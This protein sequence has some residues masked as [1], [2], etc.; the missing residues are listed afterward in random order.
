MKNNILVLL[1]LG[2]LLS[3][4]KYSDEYL[5]PHLDKSKAYFASPVM[6]TRTVI[7]GEPL[8]FKIGAAVAYDATHAAEYT[9]D[10]RISTFPIE[11]S[12]GRVALPLD[13][14]NYGSMTPTVK[15][16]LASGQLLGLF[17]VVLDSAKFLS[18]PL[19]LTGKYAIPV[20]IASTSC[21]TIDQA[22]DSVMVLVKYMAGVDGYY[23]YNSTIKKEIG[24]AII[25]SKTVT[26]N[27]PN[28]SDAYCWRLTTKGP[29][30]V[31]AVSPT[32]A[33]TV[34]S[35]FNLTVMGSTLTYVSGTG[36][37]VVTAES[38]NSYNPKTRDFTINYSYK[39]AVLNDTIYHVSANWIFRNRMVDGI[40]Q[41][42]AYLSAL[43]K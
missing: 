42:R 23:L 33:F 11:A 1:A 15:T 36:Q 41:T 35:R 10:Y 39:K 30:T 37:M 19:S 40:N 34:G 13:Y 2:I 4:C 17:P 21:D 29:Y 14:F 32:A 28:E 27:Y 24:G 6:Y 18:D 16:T 3:G 22:L 26:D 43:N 5:N 12:T 20:I 25:D 7:V 8:T 31:E 38:T 9:I